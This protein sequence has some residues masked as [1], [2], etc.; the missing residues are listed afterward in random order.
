MQLSITR[1][2][3]TAALAV[4]CLTGI[5]ADY[6]EEPE[7]LALRDS[8]NHA[9]NDGDSAR[10][11]TH[12]ARLEDYLLTKD[13][14]HA[15]YTQRCNEIVFLLNRQNV[16]EAYKRGMELSHELRERKLDKEMYMAYNMLGHIYNFTG[17]RES[18]KRCFWDVIRRM[19]EAGYYESMPPIYMNIVNVEMGQNHYEEALKQLNKAVEIAK[20]HA[21]RRLFDIETRRTMIYY[22]MGDMKRFTEGYQAYKKGVE[23]GLSSVHGR[24]ME[25]YYLA[26]QGQTDEA[27]RMAMEELGQTD[28]YSVVASIY[29][30]A[31]RWEEAYKA[32]QQGMEAN[33][34]LNS[35]ILSSNMQGIR[36]ELRTYDA[37]RKAARI[38][39]ITLSVILALLGLL[40]VA[41]GYIVMSRRRHMG[42]LKEAY[43]RALESDKM[44]TSF[45]QN[46]THEV[47]TPLNII[48][49]FAQVIMTSGND[50]TPKDWNN[51]ANVMAHNTNLITTL[52]DEML[53]LSLNESSGMAELK[54]QVQPV[55]ILEQAQKDFGH[56]LKGDTVIR[57][58]NSLPEGFVLLTSEGIFRRIIHTLIDNAVKNTSE[59]SITLLLS[60]DDDK[61][62]FAVED[63]GSGIPKGEEEHIFE[64]FTKLDEFKEGLGLG[65]PLCRIL[66]KRLGGNVKVDTGYP[67]PGAR[68]VVTLPRMEMV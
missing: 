50:L 34:S 26:L 29:E 24:Q 60:A 3:V 32:L 18:A 14:L 62:T 47:R 35:T 49:G 23:E 31:G 38:S 59:G 28:R 12:I 16:F 39:I 9:F 8:M 66:T 17:N 15:Y 65:L 54:E 21:P 10:F 2:I 61:L 13:D 43:D 56:A 46:V 52:I 22:K 33:D 67:G 4:L 55:K 45:I 58:K 42:E 40:V 51:I 36:S 27:V 5:A 37:E 11:F 64:R 25:V 1:N 48:S 68:F 57:L 20:Q 41:L 53:E 19:E 44:K 30:K 63:T 6:Q 7:Y